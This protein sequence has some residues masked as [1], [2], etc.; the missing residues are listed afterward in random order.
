M[1]CAGPKSCMLWRR[2]QHTGL[3]VGPG[4][5][6]FNS[7]RPWQTFN[8]NFGRGRLCEGSL[9]QFGRPQIHGPQWNAPTSA[10]GAGGCH[11]W[12]TRHHL[13]KVLEDRRGA[14][15]LEKSQCH[16]NLQKRQEGG[17]RELQ[18]GQPHLHPGKGDEAAYPGDPHHASGRKEGYQE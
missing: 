12:A 1:N 3:T 17:P 8:T 10:E 16:S 5:K 18:A 7:K 15:G 2:L 6:A 11:C 9:K 14:R 4:A 13:W